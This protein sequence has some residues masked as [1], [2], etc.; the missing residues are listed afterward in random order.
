[1][2]TASKTGTIVRFGTIS[3]SCTPH[4][5][6]VHPVGDVTRPRAL[7]EHVLGHPILKNHI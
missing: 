6:K 2:P 7:V 5:W 1:M 4:D 3:G